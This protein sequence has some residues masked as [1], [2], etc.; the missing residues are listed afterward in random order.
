[1][2]NILIAVITFFLSVISIR[3]A[4][5]INKRWKL[6]AKGI[7]YELVTLICSSICAVVIVFIWGI[8]NYLCH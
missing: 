3:L 5:E 2:I 7:L 1:M 6:K 4:F 8:A